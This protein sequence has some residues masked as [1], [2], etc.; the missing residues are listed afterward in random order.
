MDT[1]EDTRSKDADAD[2]DTI[3]VSVSDDS[4]PAVAVEG[5]EAAPETVGV[6]AE[7][8]QDKED[9]EEE[10]EQE[11]TQAQDVMDTSEAQDVNSDVSKG[12]NADADTSKV[13]VSQAEVVSFLEATSFPRAQV[14]AMAVGYGA[15][16]N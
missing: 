10:D 6:A 8:E 13:S 16:L 1:S 4:T 11:Q 12:V 9:E 14:I 2:A 15:W 3:K 7:Q 5:A